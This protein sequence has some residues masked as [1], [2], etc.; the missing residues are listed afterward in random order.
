MPT[1]TP[2]PTSAE[3]P[4]RK[5]RRGDRFD[6]QVEAIDDRGRGTA[7]V[8]ESRLRMRHANPGA[9][10][11]AEVLKRRGGRVEA[12]VVEV[13]DPGP[14]A[15]SARCPHA[16]VCGGCALPTLA[17]SE[18]LR[19]KRGLV[20]R[21]LAASFEANG[22]GAPPPVAEVEPASRLE[23]YRNKMDFTF[24]S[25]RYVLSEEP[26]GVDASFGLGLHAPGLFSKVLDVERCA[27]AFEGSD[28]IR[29]TVRELALAA[30]LAPWDLRAHEG[31]LRHLVVRRG[32]R[33]EETMVDLVTS[34]R[35]A[36][37]IDPLVEALL[38]RHPEITTVVQNVT[39]RAATV[40]YG[41]EEHV[42]H[43][44]GTIDEVLCGKRFRIS[45]DSFFQ[46]NTEQAERLFEIVGEA[47]GVEPGQR[48]FDVFCGAGTIGLAIAPEGVELVGFE[49]APSSIRDARQNAARNGR[50]DAV[51]HEGDVL[52]TIRLESQA[53]R[54]DVLV[55]DP[56]RAGL[57][58]KVPAQLLELG[59]DRII[60]VS[61]NP[62]SGA[63]DVAALSAGGYEV[64]E[65]RPVDLFP[66]TPHVEVV[67]TLERRP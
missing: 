18:Q 49:S 59:A 8:G 65:V 66:H 30:Q 43:G 16:G 47:A 10:V 36:G 26:D 54:P 53:R 46:T 48:L 12:R 5:P 50:D 57:H 45:A 60:F 21:A 40:A 28:G 31:L 39:S 2:E 51:F 32:V 29:N 64:T 56:P 35:A 19:Q 67:F 23:G 25:R 6:V 62:N 52:E 44:P 11:T 34:E 20:E 15:T 9:R 27:I 24:G 3:P 55:V 41:E 1:D 33:T 61:C 58:P 22:L 63:R 14:H 42:L 4:R 37:L 13:S 17:Y 38:E 7:A